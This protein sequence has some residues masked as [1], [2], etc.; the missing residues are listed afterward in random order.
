MPV[1]RPEGPEDPLLLFLGNAGTAVVH[2]DP[3]CPVHLGQRKAD[4]P[5]VRRPAKGVREQVRDHLQ[6]PVSVGLQHGPGSNRPPVVDPPSA[7]LLA[8]CRVRAVDAAI[9]RTRPEGG[10]I[11]S[12]PGIGGSATPWGPAATSSAA[13]ERASTG[14]VMR[15]ERYKPSAPATRM[16]A[17]NAGNRRQKIGS[18]LWLRRV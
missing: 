5:A 15:R 7:G 14:F 4:A 13:S 10:L 1:A 8:V 6:N 12:R 9:C 3:D 2:H 18:Q 16:P 17:K 11:S